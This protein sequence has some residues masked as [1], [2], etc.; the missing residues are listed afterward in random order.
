MMHTTLANQRIFIFVVLLLAVAPI[1]LA[2]NRPFFWMVNAVLVAAAALAYSM[3][4][5]FDS[6]RLR[7]P[8]KVVFLPSLLFFLTILWMVLQIVPIPPNVIMPDVWAISAGALG[9]N[10]SAQIS[11]D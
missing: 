4:L 7:T 8:L 1:P 10:P 3:A 9:I 2:S 6:R 5:R 11:V